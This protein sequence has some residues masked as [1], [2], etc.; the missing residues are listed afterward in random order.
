MGLG[1]HGSVK[2]FK[3]GF[4]KDR[5]LRELVERVKGR[6]NTLLMGDAKS[7]YAYLM[8]RVVN[9]LGYSRAEVTRY[10]WMT[11]SCVMRVAFDR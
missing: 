3:E 2:K 4:L 6:I 9:R 1:N 8:E 7:C 5:D 11:G 10:L